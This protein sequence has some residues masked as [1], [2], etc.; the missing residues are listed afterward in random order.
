VAPQSA[1]GFDLEGQVIEIGF[2]LMPASRYHYRDNFLEVRDGP[3]DD[4]NH[5]H[6]NKDGVLVRLHDGTDI[7]AHEGEPLVAPFSGVVIDPATRWQPWEPSRYG[8]T[9]VIVSDEPT[10]LGYVSLFAHMD[11]VWVEP[12]TRVTR[13][14]VVGTVGRTG[15]LEGQEIRTHVHFELRAPFLL[16]W[17]PLGEDRLLDAF[18]PYPSLQRADPD[19]Q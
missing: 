19:I 11:R 9:V 10:S 17:T 15:N 13:G 8:G 6:F 7:Y 12:G 4:Y 14:Q 18:D 3:P 5:A 2:P 16:D 1:S